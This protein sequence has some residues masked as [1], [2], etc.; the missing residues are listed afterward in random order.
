MDL[1]GAE[2]DDWIDAVMGNT[3]VLPT[4]ADIIIEAASNYAAGRYLARVKPDNLERSNQLIQ[5]AKEQ[6]LEYTKPFN[7]FVVKS[8]AYASS[9]LADE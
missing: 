8:K 4:P 2:A 1:F 5:L 6:I 7:A 3:A 9:P